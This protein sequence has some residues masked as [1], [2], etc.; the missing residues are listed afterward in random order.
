M[1]ERTVDAIVVGTGVIGLAT[2]RELARAG[3]TVTL[4][5][6]AQPSREASRA[7]AGI[8]CPCYPWREPA[9]LAALVHWSRALFPVLCEDLRRQTGVDPEWRVSGIMMFDAAEHAAGLDWARANAL[10]YEEL[11]PAG[12][13]RAEPALGGSSRGAF[14]LPTVGQ[15]HTG[16]LLRA[17]TEGAMNEGVPV[18]QYTE[19]TGLARENGKV[20][21]ITTKDGTLRAGRVVVAAGAWSG[22]LLE[23]A[24]LKLPMVPVHGEVLQYDGPPGLL[25]RILLERGHYVL[26]RRNGQIVVGSTK[27]RGQWEIKVSEAAQAELTAAGAALLPMLAGAT[28]N[29]Q[30]A[31]LRPGTPDELPYIGEHPDA[32]GL[33]VNTGHFRNGITLAPASARLL[34]DLVVDRP[35]I[36]PPAPFALTPERLAATVA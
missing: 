27:Q 4:V 32:A 18:R 22:K 13:A 23:A 7:A 8:V 14:Y 33:W 16:R 3:L 19:V 28:P 20:V 30:W 2:A 1:S 29:R 25:S 21:G 24:G 15:V 9:A 10:P 12:V 11:D 36:I 5:D 31:N 17:L 35:P 26:Q 34:T 6:R